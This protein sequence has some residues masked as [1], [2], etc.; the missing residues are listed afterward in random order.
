[1]AGEQAVRALV[2]FW[3]TSGAGIRY[4]AR[5]AECIAQR[6]GSANVGLALHEQNAWIDRSRVAG[7]PVMSVRGAKGKNALL[8]L[9]LQAPL[10]WLA[11]EKQVSAFRPDVVVIPMGFALAWPLSLVFRRR[12]IPIIYVAHDHEPHVGDYFVAYQEALQKVILRQAAHVVVLSEFVRRSIAAAEGLRTRT[13]C[14]LIPL[15]AHDVSLGKHARPARDPDVALLFLGRLLPY[16]GLPMLAEALE[17][18][19]ELP[20]WR[21]TIAGY[22]AEAGSVQT[23]FRHFPQVDLGWV[24]ELD[25]SEVDTLLDRHDVLVC[26]YIEASQSGALSEALYHGVPSLV[27][28]VGALPEQIGFG[29]AGWV[30]QSTSAHG[31][32]EAI[33]MVLAD[34]DTIR[35][36]TREANAMVAPPRSDAWGDVVGAVVQRGQNVRPVP[37]VMALR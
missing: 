5:V 3:G 27:T 19:R 31:L 8:G 14:T 15:S 13:P 36:A 30:A 20:G 9:A 32:R 37:D 11:L 17:H 29:R 21:L 1:M 12:R 6:L 7:H 10:R 25:E 22:G 16:K 33:R 2:W 28:P 35:R 4:A 23:R 24:R 26:P 18:F 34:P